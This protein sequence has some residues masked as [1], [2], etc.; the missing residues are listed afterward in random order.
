MMFVR[1]CGPKPLRTK[2][3]LLS[4]GSSVRSEEHQR[5]R[6]LLSYGGSVRSE[7]HRRFIKCTFDRLQHALE[8]L[9][10]YYL[11]G[12]HHVWLPCSKPGAVQRKYRHLMGNGLSWCRPRTIV[13]TVS[14]VISGNMACIFLD[15]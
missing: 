12:L 5:F 7:E 13:L 3:Q 8:L 6:Q 4:Y 10:G 9:C 14:L 1:N 11:K 15:M 2:R